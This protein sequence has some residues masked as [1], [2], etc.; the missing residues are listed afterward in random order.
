MIRRS[1]SGSKSSKLRTNF[2]AVCS[3]HTSHLASSFE[4]GTEPK[5][6][7]F[8]D[9]RMHSGNRRSVQNRM[10]D[11]CASLNNGLLSPLTNSVKGVTPLSPTNWELIFDGKPTPLDPSI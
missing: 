10:L 2:R 8:G 9:D 5:V 6:L 4:G 11:C 7:A 1:S 3:R